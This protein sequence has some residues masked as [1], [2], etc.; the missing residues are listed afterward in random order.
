MKISVISYLSSLN[1]KIKGLCIMKHLIILLLMIN[2]AFSSVTLTI[3]SL[4][5]AN[6]Y[7]T[8]YS[9]S[10][11][12]LGTL[13]IGISTDDDIMGIVMGVDSYYSFSNG[14]P[15]GGLVEE[16]DWYMSSISGNTITGYH[17]MF[18]QE[19]FIPAGTTNET[20]MYL[21]IMIF[22]DN[23]EEFCIA[24]PN[25]T[26]LEGNS[27]VVNL[28]EESCISID[29][30]EGFDS[31]ATSSNTL[32]VQVIDSYTGDGIEG[33]I[34]ELWSFSN[35]NWGMDEFNF[36]TNDSGY[37][38][39]DDFPNGLGSLS[40]WSEGY[41][42]AY[43]EFTF[44]DSGFLS[45]SMEPTGF[46]D[47]D[48]DTLVMQFIDSNT[49]QGIEGVDISLYTPSMNVDGCSNGPCT[50]Y[51]TTNELGYAVIENFP[52]GFGWMEAYAS[53][54]NAI[55]TQFTFSGT[56]ELS[57]SMD[58]YGDFDGETETLV[59]QV[60]DLNTGT[61]IDGA[62]GTIWSFNSNNSYWDEE[63]IF[64]FSTNEDGYATI[65]N[66]PLGYGFA[67]IMAQDYLPGYLQFEFTGT[68]QLTIS[69]SPSDDVG[70]NFESLVF[71]FID[72]ENGEALENV[73]G[74]AMNTSN[75]GM[76]SV[77]FDFVSDAFGFASVDFP[78]GNGV[79][80]AYKEGYQYANLQFEFTG[81]EIITVEMY[82]LNQISASITGTVNYE[83]ESNSFL[84]PFIFAMP[85]DTS[86]SS[87][88]ASV[89]VD[90]TGSYELQLIPGEYI[91]GSFYFTNPNS[92]WN[93][94]GSEN[95][96]DMGFQLQFFENSLTLESATVI[97]L[98]EGEIVDN[99]NFDFISSEFMGFNGQA[100]NIV[101]GEVTS[102]NDTNME[103]TI[104]SVVDVEGNVL[105]EQTVG[106]DQSFTITG[107]AQNEDYTLKAS[108]DEY[109]MIEK[110]FSSNSMVHIE[111]VEFNL[112]ALS[113][114]EENLGFPT[115]FSVNQNF[116]NPFNPVTTLEYS[117]P[118]NMVVQVTI[119]DNMGRLVKNLFNAS[120]R[121]GTNRIQWNA[122]DNMNQPVPT[123][124][125]I[126]RIQAG[127]QVETN[128]MIYLK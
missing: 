68:E 99:I 5:T 84:T 98:N 32:T 13:E 31:N 85:A 58:S 11:Y 125:Y 57:F 24:N 127:N 110:S 19:Y 65:E 111:N 17:Y 79:V 47:G 122:T 76:S 36:I 116:P 120:Q 75:N 52:L 27:L 82:N 106:Q 107:L 66:F 55:I 69:L 45:I 77:A 10:E 104:I 93:E 35:N 63:I 108:H 44:T 83:L 119:Y 22:L 88:G 97:Q 18:P 28:G 37:A 95:S 43:L 34:G 70:N 48:T 26:D 124:M 114:D 78:V 6:E 46:T 105:S 40:L 7:G 62:S 42:P 39:I 72:A 15:Y 103:G 91:V 112:G 86:L 51:A 8:T 25:F 53:G 64:S 12:L 117:I 1:Y 16:L 92:D 81:N 54:Y 20:L 121:A 102:D 74:Y 87:Y 113:S 128:K 3:E 61:G 71:Q 94:N 118:E 2:T 109:G 73:F 123:G 21:P 96:N 89:A 115:A 4:T 29:E 30:L 14:L 67:E 23:D 9:G 33:A 100:G 101:M 49:G 38:F 56:E 80:E 41:F 126:Y 50:I 59:V 60:V 90:G